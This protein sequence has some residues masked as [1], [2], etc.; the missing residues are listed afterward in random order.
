MLLN[1][2]FEQGQVQSGLFCPFLVILMLSC[3][4][5]L[6]LIFE[7]SQAIFIIERCVI[8][9]NQW[10]RHTHISGTFGGHGRYLIL[11]QR[12][13]HL[14]KIATGITNACFESAF[15]I[16]C[17]NDDIFSVGPFQ[18]IPPF[19]VFLIEKLL[20]LKRR[21]TLSY[22]YSLVMRNLFNNVCNK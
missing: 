3:Q 21:V 2:I 13:S 22:A 4:L 19:L 17:S 12:S 10:Q 6:Y 9:C 11:R 20:I 5:W 14:T 7:R 18:S 16:V 8:F 15:D 1:L